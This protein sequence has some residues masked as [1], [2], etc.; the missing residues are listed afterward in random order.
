MIKILAIGNSFSQDATAYLYQ[1]AASGGV[2]IKVGNLCIGGCS[3]ERHHKNLCED[4]CDYGYE[5][6]GRYVGE[7]MTLQAGLCE[8]NWDFVTMQQASH[9]SGL[10][11]TYYPH[12]TELSAYVKQYVPN[13]AQIIHQTWAY[14]TDSNHGAF[15][16]YDCDQVKMYN[17]LKSSYYN[18]AVRLNLGII[19]SGEI[20]QKLRLSE[21]FDYGKGKPSLCR[22]GFHMHL[23]Y[24][25][26]TIAAAWYEM[27][28]GGD[29]LAAG[30]LPD[31]PTYGKMSAAQLD[32][33][34]HTVRE[35][36]NI[37]K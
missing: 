19:P 7:T 1:I 29:I 33:I 28:C 31:Q 10:P 15:T 34:S 20:I 27:L 36:C 4:L 17:M 21:E 24:G 22:D 6:N 37:Y 18:A 16:V 9:F 2:D 5:I 3:L 25:R 12:I 23:L 11:E 8:D 32:V 13:A 26:Y 35:I 30:F 14:E